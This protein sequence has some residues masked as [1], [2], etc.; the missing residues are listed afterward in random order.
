MVPATSREPGTCLIAASFSK[1]NWRNSDAKDYPVKRCFVAL[2]GLTHQ[3]SVS[4]TANRYE[5]KAKKNARVE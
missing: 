2:T 4:W 5:A 3:F 1:T